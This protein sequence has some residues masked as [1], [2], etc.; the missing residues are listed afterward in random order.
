MKRYRSEQKEEV[1]TPKT[2]NQSVLDCDFTF[3]K[4]E[5]ETAMERLAV[6]CGDYKHAL[7]AYFE[8]EEEAQL[9]MEEYAKKGKSP[10]HIESSEEDADETY[11]DDWN[12]PENVA[13]QHVKWAV[14]AEKAKEPETESNIK[15][16]Q[17]SLVPR[18][19]CW[20]IHM[21]ILGISKLF[22]ERKAAQLFIFRKMQEKIPG[23]KVSGGSIMGLQT[24]MGMPHMLHRRHG[25]EGYLKIAE[26]DSD[27]N[28]VSYGT[29]IAFMRLNIRTH[30]WYFN[31]PL[32]CGPYEHPNA[33]DSENPLYDD[34][35]KNWR[36]VF[37]ETFMSLHNEMSE[38]SK[39]KKQHHL[40][41]K[42]YMMLL[43]KGVANQLLQLLLCHTIG[44]LYYIDMF[45]IWRRAHIWE[46][47]RSIWKGAK[48]TSLKSPPDQQLDHK[49]YYDLRT[50]M[51]FGKTEQLLSEPEMKQLR[52]LCNLESRHTPLNTCLSLVKGKLTWEEYYD[53]VWEYYEHDLGDQKFAC[54]T[55]LDE[56]GKWFSDWFTYSLEWR[57]TR[58]LRD[59]LTKEKISF[60][61]SS[62]FGD[63]DHHVY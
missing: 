7:R 23:L 49:D 30:N 41:R 51:M 50:G 39:L 47:A 45:G 14:K 3:I 31:L 37:Q 36:S 46:H 22:Q 18:S 16:W 59:K 55:L 63:L 52:E 33:V 53:E 5:P 19:G 6:E 21:P 26:H 10:W 8:T 11:G 61:I 20:I 1:K 54:L 43:V 24:E 27:A 9:D 4:C 32:G 29:C 57:D 48:R 15:A 58:E 60:V 42:Y 28:D 2:W 12:S 13:K 40:N 38:I 44:N 56:P 62:E 17:D 35:N 34:E 25:M